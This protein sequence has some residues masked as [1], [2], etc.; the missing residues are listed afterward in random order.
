M[1]SVPVGAALGAT[2]GATVGAA[3]ESSPCLG[4]AA[5]FRGGAGASSGAGTGVWAVRC[6]VPRELASV[7][8]ARCSKACLLNCSGESHAATLTG[9]TSTKNVVQRPT[10]VRESGCVQVSS[11]QHSGG[12]GREANKSASAARPIPAQRTPGRKDG[13]RKE[14]TRPVKYV[15]RRTE[16]H[17]PSVRNGIQRV[18][19]DGITGDAG[20]TACWRS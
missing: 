13:C 10:L 14:A 16:L 5:G 17:I 4:A 19:S 12:V 20:A 9:S 18:K 7:T 6:L 2:V 1:A 15:P 11:A 8:S 3:T